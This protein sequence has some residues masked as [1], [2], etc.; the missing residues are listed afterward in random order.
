MEK[1]ENQ[2][3]GFWQLPDNF[4]DVIIFVLKFNKN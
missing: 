4:V 1:E 3:L 2:L